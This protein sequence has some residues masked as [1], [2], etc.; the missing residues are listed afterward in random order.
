[1]MASTDGNKKDPARQEAHRV[2]FVAEIS[3]SEGRSSG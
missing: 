1:M 3:S 2:Y